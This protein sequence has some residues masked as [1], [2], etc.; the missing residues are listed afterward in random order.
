MLHP[1]YCLVFDEMK[2]RSMKTMDRAATVSVVSCA[3]F[4]TSF[5]VFGYIYC[6]L[7]APLTTYP[8][9]DILS[10]FPANL[11][12]V[13]VA[14]FGIAIS[15]I[16]SYVA[17]HFGARTCIQ[18]LVLPQGATFSQVVGLNMAK[19]IDKPSVIC[20]FNPTLSDNSA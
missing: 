2:E 1:T 12:D 16:S 15:V 5:G 3:G 8:P 14:R 9:G 13:A 4:Y 18:D 19:S 17:L 6:A 11:A 7:H 20:I 10:A